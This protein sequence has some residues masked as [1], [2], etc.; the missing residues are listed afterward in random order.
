MERVDRSDGQHDLLCGS[1]LPNV[2]APC[3]HL[4]RDKKRYIIHP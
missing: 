2:A 1:V 3:T 4:V